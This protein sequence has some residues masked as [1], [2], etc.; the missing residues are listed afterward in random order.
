MLLP[1]I[2]VCFVMRKYICPV[3]ISLFKI[4]IH[5]EPMAATSEIPIEKFRT[6]FSPKVSSMKF[7]SIMHAN[8][9]IVKHPPWKFIETKAILWI[10]IRLFALSTNCNSNVDMIRVKEKILLENIAKRRKS[11]STMSYKDWC[12]GVNFTN[13]DYVK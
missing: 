11:L 12:P 2:T 9:A 8:R 7:M 13:L 5:E 10:I 6:N 3:F 4:W 1:D